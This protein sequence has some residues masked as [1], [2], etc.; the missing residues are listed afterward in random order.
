[1][2]ARFRIDFD[3]TLKWVAARRPAGWQ[4]FLLGVLI[5]L[6]FA[7]SV[8]LNNYFLFDEDQHIAAGVLFA[9]E[10]L[11]PYRDFP[12]FHLPY[13]IYA[14]G[15]LF[16]FTDH[17]LLAARLFSAVCAAFTGGAIFLAAWRLF[18]MY[19]VWRRLLIGGGAVVLL[20][21]TPLFFYTAGH[22][23]NQE[24]STLF[25]LL[26]FLCVFSAMRRPSAGAR[27]VLGG[28]LLGIAIGLRVTMAPL[29]LPFALRIGFAA[30]STRQQQRNIVLFG[31]GVALAMLPAAWAFA[32]A[33]RGFIFGNMEFPRVNI[34]Y[35]LA[36]AQPHT[37]TVTQKL[38]FFLKWF[39][40]GGNWVLFHG[41]FA[42]WFASR[43]RQRAPIESSARLLS[44]LFLTLPFLLL[45][46]FAPS[47]FAKQYFYPL[48]PF[49]VLG[50]L[51]F[52]A[53][54]PIHLRRLRWMWAAAAVLVA[55]S[56]ARSWSQ[57]EPC[58]RFFRPQTWYVSTLRAD[59]SRLRDLVPAG[60][61]LTLTP[62]YPLE[63]G[64]QIYPEFVTGAFAMR[65]SPFVVPER[66]SAL[67]L[68]APDDL[69]ARL[70]GDPPAAILVG[71][72][73]SWEKPF[74]RYAQS[75][76]YQRTPFL[77]DQE[78]WMAPANGCANKCSNSIRPLVLSRSEARSGFER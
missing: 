41:F 28:A 13:L 20:I 8:G 68:L 51:G 74:V 35:L 55:I 44:F 22:A 42:A 56:A 53:S 6:P 47:P 65:V 36:S 3:A 52:F 43:F 25:A 23:W 33:P 73:Q 32:T 34:D 15:F 37:V 69:E 46:A 77:K 18:E 62:T 75:H 12:Y 78:L 16:K 27:L 59:A 61:I 38:R 57:Y 71:L 24:P 40:S 39:F 50:I 48:V 64:L 19:S 45:G 11:V 60:R 49:L 21:S 58:L 17:Y 10:G 76:G 7:L 67:R 66:R 31:L 29:F 30:D 72:R 9:R 70:A 2:S 54:V 4:I 63:A 26:A 5:A 14:Y 1:M